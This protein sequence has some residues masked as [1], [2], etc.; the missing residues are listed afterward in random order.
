M[1][2][3]GV[4]FD[5]PAGLEDSSTYGYRSR[6]AYEEL[7]VEFELPVGAATPADEVI[8]EIREG[9]EGYFDAEFSIV[10]QGDQTFLGQPG[11]FLHYRLDGAEQVVSKIVVA[12][13]VRADGTRGDWIKLV[14]SGEP[15]AASAGIDAIVDPIVAS[16]I[17][18]SGGARQ[19]VLP[20]HVRQQA[21]DWVLDVPAHLAGPRTFVYEDTVA[22]LRIEVKVL[23]PGASEPDLDPDSDDGQTARSFAKRRVDLVGR[24]A[25][26]HRWVV[27]SASGPSREATRLTAI[28]G[29]L[30]ASVRAEEMT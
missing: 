27:L 12:N 24:Q 14:W 19:P 21:G 25:G 7:T 20:G 1:R 6:G 11:K 3:D 10:A 15:A 13:A 18:A 5:A 2:V 17:P 26:E 22:E 8:A 9:L 23:P 16:F 4:A 28:V 29:A 30:L